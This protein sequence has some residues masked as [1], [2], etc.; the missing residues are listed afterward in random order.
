MRP[1]LALVG[2]FQLAACGPTMVV[3]RD[4]ATGQVAQ[5]RGDPWAWDPAG[6][7]AACAR[8]YVA[9]GYVKMGSN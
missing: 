1:T 2:L 6:D 3:L 7:T 9:A 4:P 5:C 8:G